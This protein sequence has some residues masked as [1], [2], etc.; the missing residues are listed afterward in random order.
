MV[1]DG[2]SNL[3]SITIPDTVK[4]IGMG[5]FRGCSSLTTITLPSGLTV[6]EPMVFSNCTS[7]KTVNNMGNLVAIRGDAF[8]G[9]EAL[10]ELTLPAGLQVLNAGAFAFCTSLT[11][12][13]FSG[14][15]IA[16]LADTAFMGVTAT[17]YHPNNDFWTDL[18]ANYTGQGT[19]TWVAD[20]TLST[21]VPGGI[22]WSYD[23]ANNRLYFTGEGAIPGYSGN[24]APW[25][26]MRN[27]VE[28]IYFGAGISAIGDGAFNHA[29]FQSLETVY[30][31]GTKAQWEA[32]SKGANEFLL[33]A[34][35]HHYNVTTTDITAHYTITVKEVLAGCGD[36][37]KVLA[38]ACSEDT[39]NPYTI[40]ITTGTGTGIH[41]E[42]A[43]GF[44]TGCGAAVAEPELVN[45]YYIIKNAAHLVWFGNR[46]NTNTMS[47]FVNARLAADIDLNPGI[48]VSA[49]T[50]D[51]RV[52]TVPTAVQYEGK[53]DGAG[54]VI[55]GLYI[56]GENDYAG[57]FGHTGSNA[58][59]TG[60]TISN[61]YI[62]GRDYVGGI[63]GVGS[64]TPI[65]DCSIIGNVTITGREHVGGIAGTAENISVCTTGNGVAVRGRSNVGGIVG[66]TGGHISACTNQASVSFLHTGNETTNSAQC[67]GGIAG[68]LGDD[69]NYDKIV[70]NCQNTGVIT[71]NHFTGGIVGYL[72]NGTIAG[73]G[74]MGTVSGFQSVGGICGFASPLNSY[75]NNL[76]EIRNCYNSA[77]VSAIH[78]LGGIVGY[79]L[80]GS[81]VTACWNYGTVRNTNVDNFGTTGGVVGENFGRV[82]SCYAGCSVIGA[83]G[84]ETGG[85]C[86]HVYYS[87]SRSVATVDLD[88][89]D[90]SVGNGYFK[91]SVT[92][93]SSGA[94]AGTLDSGA[95]VADMYIA[96]S[97][98]AVGANNGG[99]VDVSK[100]TDEQFASGEVC[101]L[102]NGGVTDG[103]QL[104]YQ[105]LGTDSAPT[106]TKNTAHT[107]YKGYNCSGAAYS[108]SPLSDTPVDHALTYTGEGAVLTEACANCDHTATATL[109]FSG[110]VITLTC[111]DAW[112]GDA[113]TVAVTKNDRLTTDYTQAGTYIAT[114]SMKD[115]AATLTF[116]VTVTETQ[117]QLPSEKPADAVV[118]LT[119]TEISG[120]EEEAKA[121]EEQG[122]EVIITANVKYVTTHADA[123]KLGDVEA[124]V[125]I[126]L[127][128][129]VDGVETPITEAKT[130]QGY[131]IPMDL[132]NKANFKVSRVHDGAVQTFTRVY[133]TGNPVDQSFYVDTVN[134]RLIIFTSCYSL[135]GIGYDTTANITYVDGSARETTTYV[136]G[137]GTTLKAPTKT[138]YT[139]GGWYSDKALTERVTAITATD[140]GE[141][142][143]YAK[144]T[145][146][147]YTVKF[148]ANGGTGTASALADRTVTY[149][150]AYGTLPTVTKDGMYFAGWYTDS[151]L[152]KQVKATSLVSIAAD[153]TLYAKWSSVPVTGDASGADLA[154]YGMALA[155]SLAAIA[156]IVGYR[157]KKN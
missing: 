25:G 49:S 68:N 18:I 14:S 7:L 71:G 97:A 77:G 45:G 94:V 133:T 16:L 93:G 103:T 95:S 116:Y 106:L 66:S 142:V 56:P 146:N 84:G 154:L 86:G 136:V 54:Y 37:Y 53:F 88:V 138:G 128:K 12:V 152:T 134:N 153:H 117:T 82:I 83:S 125:E 4:T 122:K 46:I 57:L 147:T 34:P 36:G 149:D 28:E 111:D 89:S 81:N 109:A 124:L 52:W 113:A 60:I 114:A 119:K 58:A 24:G 69:S 101:W 102:L 80:G 72:Q 79:N 135:Y 55:S 112:L 21:D 64:N 10:T 47:P 115:A 3:S 13:T 27:F 78:F 59:L 70:E 1:F 118:D 5:A 87:G 150:S 151:A 63:V 139:F 51:A 120:L 23:E 33:G 127:I 73:C 30:Y 91:G 148:N 96:D 74:N 155:L 144:W 41:T 76:A 29:K 8:N 132:S 50:T 108:N 17:V 105:N 121:N 20:S 26:E 85:I 104:W 157:K 140:T 123:D 137:M 31:A 156:G 44:C 19:L 130:V 11:K 143:L 6:I 141:F 15:N 90:S 75:G 99:T 67:F 35:N 62:S 42:G 32:M 100:M 92:G 107:V 61:S 98:Q 65:T 39:A 131:A 9:C 145:A 129:S 126:T 110:G 48:T 38:C 43:D 2:C 22:K 40:T